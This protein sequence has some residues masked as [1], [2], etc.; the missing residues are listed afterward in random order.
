MRRAIPATAR[1]TV[2]A[3]TLAALAPGR[4]HAAG[5]VPAADAP[6]VVVTAPPDGRAGAVCAVRSP[7]ATGLAITLAPAALAPGSRL[8][9][10]TSSAVLH[11]VLDAAALARGVQ[12]PSAPGGPG[13]ASGAVP[14][15]DRS[16]DGDTIFLRL[17][18]PGGGSVRVERIELAPDAAWAAALAA[19]W[20]PHVYQD[21]DR[22]GWRYDLITAFDFDGD[23]DGDNNWE[24]AAGARDLPLDGRPEHQAAVYWWA[25]ESATHWFVGYAFF[26][27]RDWDRL[28]WFGR[29]DREHVN[30]MEGIVVYVRKA[31]A[32]DPMGAAELIQT[33]NHSDHRQYAAPGAFRMRA[34]AGGGPTSDP[35]RAR[36]TVDGPLALEGG[37]PVVYIEAQGHGVTG[38]PFEHWLRG[39]RFDGRRG[40]G[41]H[42]VP[43]TYPL[44]PIGPLWRMAH[45]P[46][47]HGPHRTFHDPTRFQGATH[48]K[49]HAA[50]PPWGWDDADLARLGYAAG[51]GA[52]FGEPGLLVNWQFLPR[53]P[54][55]APILRRT[56]D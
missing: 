26:H 51:R 10:F 43:G 33:I 11:Q 5:P 22:S 39:P 38:Q 9:V 48:G 16:L 28:P 40:D 14:P 21:C 42:Y 8:E 30:D 34:A 50:N 15:A 3:V 41:V 4:V 49:K 47:Y 52:L 31:L 55:A 19:R 53:E 44:K 23:L 7:G 13:G 54:V 35:R 32:G 18:A 24:T 20:A 25:A 37:H 56:W 17:A 12:I 27:P 2:L 29:E 6:A 36:E 45:D 1:A 46:A